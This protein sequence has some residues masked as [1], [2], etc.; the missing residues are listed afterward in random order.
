MK[1]D[2]LAVLGRLRA[3]AVTEASR[4]L[5]AARGRAKLSSDGIEAQAL[6]IRQEQSHAL[7]DDVAAFAAWLPHARRDSARLQAALAIEDGQMRRL[8]QV[9]IARTTDAEAVV[10]AIERRNTEAALLLARKEQSVMDEA[11]GWTHRRD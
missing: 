7:G 9:L 5:A 10:K 11:A 3:A 4:D 2:A 8:Q 6:H 1:R